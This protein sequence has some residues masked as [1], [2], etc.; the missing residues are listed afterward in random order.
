MT[1]GEWLDKKIEN[2]IDKCVENGIKVSIGLVIVDCI[3]L[4][5]M[6]K[7]SPM[8]G[9]FFTICSITIFPFISEVV[10]NWKEQE[11]KEGEEKNE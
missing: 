2:F 8:F 10:D 9:V 5:L 7:V 4:F 3:F 1:N 11:H 6:I